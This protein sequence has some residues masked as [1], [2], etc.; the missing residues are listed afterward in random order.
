MV[1]NNFLK[2]LTIASAD[3]VVEQLELSHI[4]CEN[5]QWSSH[6]ANCLVVSY[7]VKQTLPI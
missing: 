6:V 4:A 3:K 1:K 5:A 2:K 7:K